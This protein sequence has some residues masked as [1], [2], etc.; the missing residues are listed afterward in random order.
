MRRLRVAA[1]DR[2]FRA[3]ARTEPSVVLALLR[4]V[5][6]ELLAGETV[7][8]TSVE[9]P[10]LD[11]PRPSVAR[12]AVLSYT[13]D[14]MNEIL[15]TRLPAS[16]LKRL[17]ERARKAGTT[18]SALVRALL[19]EQLG[20]TTADKSALELTRRWVGAIRSDVVVPGRRARSALAGW[21]PDRRG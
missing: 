8:A 5:V 2:A 10:K 3:L 20:A 17:R 19:E 16:L 11:L 6:P 15:T 13:Y 18:P 12:P 14:I 21:R 7:D 9:E 4:I 1:T